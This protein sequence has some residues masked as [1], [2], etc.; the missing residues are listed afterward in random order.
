MYVILCSAGIFWV[1]I[2][3]VGFCWEL[4]ASD[5]FHRVMLDSVGLYRAWLGSVAFCWVLLGSVWFYQA[6]LVPESLPVQ[7]DEDHGG[8]GEEALAVEGQVLLLPGDVQHV[9]AAGE[10][11][12]TNT[13]INRNAHNPG[14]WLKHTR[15]PILI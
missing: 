1:L 13:S 3:S 6:Y 11:T 8:V 5:G 12:H 10:H 15:S 2:C 7:G 14:H 4:M 9:S